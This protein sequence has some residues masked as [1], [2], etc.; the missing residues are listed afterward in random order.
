[1][2]LSS[3]FDTGRIPE[4]FCAQFTESSAQ[5]SPAHGNNKSPLR[6]H[7]NTSM[8]EQGTS[9]DFFPTSFV[10]STSTLSSNLSMLHPSAIHAVV[11]HVRPSENHPLLLQTNAKPHSV[12][13]AL[14]TCRSTIIVYSTHNLP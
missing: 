7:L 4:A 12:V 3:R 9:P 8:G 2:Y 11:T 5:L 1:M 6:A 14:S 10:P 13:I